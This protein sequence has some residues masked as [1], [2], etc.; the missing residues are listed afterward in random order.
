M[1][2]TKRYPSYGDIVDENTIFAFSPM[3]ETTLLMTLLCRKMSSTLNTYVPVL[4]STNYQEWAARMQSYLMSQ[5]QWRVINKSAPS[6]VKDE[7]GSVTNQSALDDWEENISKAVGNIRLRL[8]HTIAYQFNTEENVADLWT[9]LAA[10]YGKPGVSRAFMEFKGAMDATIPNNSDPQ[11]AI[12]KMSAHFTR[13]KDIGFE[14]P[15]RV[16]AMMYLSKAPSRW[17]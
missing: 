14:I 9:A 3:S 17:K 7:A 1:L 12:D 5:G 11:P 8:H 4:D 10:K 13:L 16:Q 15:D 2:K 6:E